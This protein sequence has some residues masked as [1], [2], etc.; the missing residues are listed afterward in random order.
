[1]R[2]LHSLEQNHSVDEQNGI[3][4]HTDVECFTI[5]TQDS[6]DSLEV[7][8]KPGHWV[9]ADPVPSALIVNIAD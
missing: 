1:M 8:S 2:I 6:S 9:K 3:S 5:V 4:T 7:L